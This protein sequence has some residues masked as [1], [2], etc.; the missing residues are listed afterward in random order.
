[1]HIQARATWSLAIATCSMWIHTQLAAQTPQPVTTQ[2]QSFEVQG[3]TLLAPHTLQQVL[4]TTPTTMSFEDL[5]AAAQAL[6]TAYRRAGYGAVIVQLPQQT[7]RNGSVKLQVVEG[8]LSS[9]QV[10]GYTGF[11]RDNILRAL[12]SLAIAQTPHLSSLDSELLMINENPAKSVRV[13]LQPGQNQGDVEAL[14][15]VE[16][17][18]IRRWQL[19]LDNS[20]NA[21]TGKWRMSGNYQHANV[22]DRDIVWGVRMVTSPTKPEHVLVLGSTL[23]VPL[24]QQRMFIEGSFMASN[25]RSENNYTP[26]GELRFSGKGLAVGARALWLLPSLREA[27]SQAALGVDLRSY[28]NDCSLGEFGSAGCGPAGASVDVAPLTASYVLQK[29]GHYALNLSYVVNLPLGKAGR[30]DRFNASRPGARSDYRVARLHW[31]MQHMVAPQWSLLWRLD[32]QWAPRA[33]VSAEQLGAGGST[34]V[35]G[36]QERESIG[37]SGIVNSFELRT[38]LNTFT[39]TQVHAKSA[40]LSVFW[41]AAQVRNQLNTSCY[42]HHTRCSTWSTGFGVLMHPHRNTSL[43]L[44]V[45]RAGKSALETQRGDWRLH[46]SLS[47]QL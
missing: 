41:D 39:G 1:M 2:V 40:L 23:R 35:R 46:V 20:G 11:S 26:A 29:S 25:V 14:V 21:S 6:Q 19:Q 37:D 27:K 28:K 32:A 34:S 38:P 43:R 16:E 15:A 3:N 7:I 5:Q 44:D 24:Y 31:G 13:V 4:P 36:Y 45:A 18:A 22:A 12:P 30:D 42:R 47:H 33:L 8:K 9:I 10:A 17:Q